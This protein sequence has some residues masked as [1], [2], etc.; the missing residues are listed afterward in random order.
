MHT[1][2]N[3]Y[4]KNKQAE[5]RKNNTRTQGDVRQV[6]LAVKKGFLNKEWHSWV[7]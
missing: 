6:Q 1:Y 5:K 2:K 7:N 3:T 4:K